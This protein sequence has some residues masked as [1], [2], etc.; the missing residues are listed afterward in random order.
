MPLATPY[1][2]TGNGQSYQSSVQPTYDAAFRL[3]RCQDVNGAAFNV[4]DPSGSFAVGGTPFVAGSMP[5]SQFL[6]AIS[7]VERAALRAHTDPLVKEFVTMCNDPRFTTINTLLPGIQFDV[8]Y[9]AGLVVAPAG[10]TN[11]GAL[12]ANPPIAGATRAAQILAGNVSA[13]VD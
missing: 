5:M 7:T 2:L 8:N 11:A 3:W 13:T 1:T 10:A 4:N 9:A 6:T 12:I